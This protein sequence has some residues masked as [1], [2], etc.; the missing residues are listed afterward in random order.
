M[1]LTTIGVRELV[2]PALH[3]VV[4]ECLERQLELLVAMDIV[5]PTPQD[6]NFEKL[7]V[8]ER[9]SRAWLLA[10]L[11]EAFP[12]VYGPLDDPATLVT[13]RSRV[14]ENPVEIPEPDRLI[15][16]IPSSWSPRG[17]GGR[18]L[19]RLLKRRVIWKLVAGRPRWVL[20][21]FYGFGSKTLREMA[22]RRLQDQ[23]ELADWRPV[24]NLEAARGHPRE[25]IALARSGRPPH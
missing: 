25:F 17:L 23:V 9:H 4:R 19:L 2:D 1:P 12:E 10:E 21:L 5:P 16:E 20:L 24:S 14:F 15:A 22:H 6:I 7:L 8:E 13:G 18:E 11:Y 3:A